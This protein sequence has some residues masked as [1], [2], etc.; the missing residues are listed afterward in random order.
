M[1]LREKY[2]N[3]PTL[4]AARELVGKFLVRRWRGREI[5]GMITEVEAYDG[6]NDKASH[7]SR[8]MTARNA[9]MFGGAGRWYVYF[10]YGMHWLLNIVTREKGYP[11][12]IL[13]RGAAVTSSLRGGR[14]RRPTKQSHDNVRL[15]QPTAVGFAMTT[16]IN[17]P[18][19]LTKYFHI[20]KRFNGK[21]AS[22]KIGL[23]IED[24]GV[25]VKNSDIARTPRIGVAYAGKVWS[26]KKYRF[27]TNKA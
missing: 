4:V 15:P 12:A 25:R 24:R 21:P 1:I 8:G 6:W 11:A 20:D 10:T 26:G 23:W 14:P 9:P 18:A 7:A 3:R 22:K 16:P 13:I 19:R 27:L 2:F 17:G 5:T